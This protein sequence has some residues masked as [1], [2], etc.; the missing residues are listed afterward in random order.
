MRILPL[1]LL[2]PSICFAQW[3]TE[4]KALAAVSMAALAIDYGQTLNVVKRPDK[5]REGNPILSSYPS[6]GR[7]NAYFVIVPIATYLALDYM[8]TDTRTL[9]LRVITSVQV[10]VVAHNY[11]I[12]VR[13]SF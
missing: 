13:T 12:G 9:A 7:V 8:S 1:L 11:S 10:A 4:Q 2:V 5:Y 3:T 6:R